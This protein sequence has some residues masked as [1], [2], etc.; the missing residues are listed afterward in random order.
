MEGKAVETG[1]GKHGLQRTSEMID[2]WK[3]DSPLDS[4]VVGSC[5]GRLK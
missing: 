2:E 3:M 4:S 5:N 1:K